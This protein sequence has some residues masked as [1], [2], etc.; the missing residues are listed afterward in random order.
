[1]AAHTYRQQET[2][3][4][5]KIVAESSVAAGIRRIEAITGA[6]VDEYLQK[7]ENLLAQLT[8]TLKNPQDLLRAVENLQAEK[9][10]LE[11]KL[12]IL[13]KEQ[14]KTL[15]NELQ[16]KAEKVGDISVIAATVEVSSANLLKDLAY[17]LK[18]KTSRSFYSLSRSS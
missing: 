15:A 11:K 4:L 5:F 6:R 16:A 7:K 13:E 9:T 2:L 17:L 10:S 8:E 18:E 14:L 3:A 12:E 1:M